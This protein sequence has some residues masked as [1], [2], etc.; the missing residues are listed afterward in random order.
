MRCTIDSPNTNRKARRDMVMAF[1]GLC[2]R[3]VLIRP[4]SQ[5]VVVIDRLAAEVITQAFAFVAPLARS[6]KGNMIVRDP[7]GKV[8]GT[9]HQNINPAVLANT[10][11]M[12]AASTSLRPIRCRVLSIRP[13]VKG[14]EAAMTTATAKRGETPSSNRG[15][16]TASVSSENNGWTEVR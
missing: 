2:P 10:A 15:R 9:D 4:D 16:V 5:L 13:P 1:L 11:T 7:S 12:S 3:N 8:S 6:Q 14:A